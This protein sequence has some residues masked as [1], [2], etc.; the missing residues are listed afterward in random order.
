MSTFAC[1]LE[2]CVFLSS[3]T[4]KSKDLDDG[5]E[6]FKLSKAKINCSAVFKVSLNEWSDDWLFSPC[7]HPLPSLSVLARLLLS[8]VSIPSVHLPYCSPQNDRHPQ[9]QQAAP[10]INEIIQKVFCYSAF[11]SLF[12]PY[13]THLLCIHKSVTSSRAQPII[14]Q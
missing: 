9:W 5:E 12:E 1:V 11:I 8:T 10:G 14:E 3:N 13:A 2:L 6:L 4:Q 7:L